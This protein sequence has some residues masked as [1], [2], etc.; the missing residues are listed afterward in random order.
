MQPGLYSFPSR[1]RQ[2]FK[3]SLIKREYNPFQNLP[4]LRLAAWPLG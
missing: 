3:F 1:R 4:Y 2:I